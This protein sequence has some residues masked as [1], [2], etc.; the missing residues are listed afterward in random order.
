MTRDS[1]ETPPAAEPTPPPAPDDARE[2]LGLEAGSVDPLEVLPV[3][4]PALEELAPPVEPFPEALAEDPLAEPPFVPEPPRRAGPRRSIP[5]SSIPTPS[6]SSTAC[7]RMATRPTS[8][9][10]A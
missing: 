7:T 2:A 8:W 1:T 9:A 3:P 6:R 4:E 5:T 10:G